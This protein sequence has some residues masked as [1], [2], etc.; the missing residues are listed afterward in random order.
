VFN[1]TE[2]AIAQ[3]VAPRS[4]GWARRRPFRLSGNYALWNNGGTLSQRD[5]E[6]GINTVIDCGAGTCQNDMIREGRGGLLGGDGYEI[7][8]YQAGNPTQLT[9]DLNYVNTNPQ[10]DGKVVSIEAAIIS[11]SYSVSP[12]LKL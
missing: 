1:L 8:R 3:D 7:F 10:T 11:E 5:L 6:T 9:Y 12:G 4:G 2:A